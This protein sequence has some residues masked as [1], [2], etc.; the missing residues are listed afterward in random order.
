MYN[1]PHPS[2][3]IKETYLDPFNISHHDLFS[4]KKKEK[5]KSLKPFSFPK[6]SFG[7]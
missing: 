3:F 5:W 7:Q 6:V 4:V 2:E 1:P